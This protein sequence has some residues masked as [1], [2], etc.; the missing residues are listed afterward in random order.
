MGGPT[1]LADLL[2][3]SLPTDELEVIVDAKRFWRFRRWDVAVLL[4]NPA[5]GVRYVVASPGQRLTSRRRLREAPDFNSLVSLVRWICGL[6]EIAP[7]ALST[8]PIRSHG[9][10][11]RRLAE[12]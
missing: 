5:S 7:T 11:R 9:R 4:A 6:A 12:S 10:A 3:R 2:Q 1:L 8:A